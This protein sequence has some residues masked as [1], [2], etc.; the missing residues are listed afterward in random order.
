MKDA[1][2]PSIRISELTANHTSYF[3]K[4]HRH[5]KLRWADGTPPAKAKFAEAASKIAKEFKL[6]TYEVECARYGTTPVGASTDTNISSKTFTNGK[7]EDD[8][9]LKSW[10]SSTLPPPSEASFSLRISGI[11]STDSSNLKPSPTRLIICVANKCETTYKVGKHDKQIPPSCD[12]RVTVQ[13]SGGMVESFE[14]QKDIARHYRGLLNLVER[15]LGAVQ[16]R[17]FNL[18]LSGGGFRATLFHIG[19]VRALRDLGLLNSLH[20]VSS[21]SGGSIVAGD[22]FANWRDYASSDESSFNHRVEKLIDLASEDLRRRVSLTASTLLALLYATLSAIVVGLYISARSAFS[23]QSTL[24]AELYRNLTTIFSNSPEPEAASILSITLIILVTCLLTFLSIK[25]TGGIIGQ[26][27]GLATWLTHRRLSKLF[28]RSSLEDARKGS[29]EMSTQ[30]SAPFFFFN[31]TS[32]NS[33]SLCA[34]TGYGFIRDASTFSDSV[35]RRSFFPRFSVVSLG[36]AVTASAAFPVFFGPVRLKFNKRLDRSAHE[37]NTWE[38]G[39]IESLADGGLFDNS[40]VSLLRN[41]LELNQNFGV[42]NQEL[43]AMIV[44]DAASA[45]AVT[46]GLPYRNS[47]LRLGRSINILMD[48]KSIE[49]LRISALDPAK[50][51]VPIEQAHTFGNDLVQPAT[52]LKPKIVKYLAHTRTDLDR[53]DEHIIRGLI[54]HG[55]TGLLHKVLS[56]QPSGNQRIF[57]STTVERAKELVRG[58]WYQGY[59]DFKQL[60]EHG[61]KIQ[62]DSGKGL[63]ALLGRETRG[64]LRVAL[65]LFIR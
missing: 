14:D 44:S 53:F 49:M 9:P 54:Q 41:N 55:Y 30:G 28:N 52:N 23:A 26:F 38:G 25:A 46:T 16:K 65:R 31:T 10:L 3:C 34:F 18:A 59:T 33:A 4:M 32:L 45:I 39:S 7:S 51:V 27:S 47:F 50:I 11:I 43:A 36:K 61:C 62:R 20:S 63:L 40:G 5:Y 24:I 57:D 22:L 17:A 8:I 42:P 60:N 12:L 1:D 29:R 48:S 64:F 2:I 13:F 19:V 35:S 56:H 15:E 37:D 58:D 6:A 21:V